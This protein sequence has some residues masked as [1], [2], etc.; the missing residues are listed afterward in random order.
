MIWSFL[1]PVTRCWSLEHPSCVSGPGE[2][3]ALSMGDALLSQPTRKG[4][5]LLFLNIWLAATMFDVTQ[6]KS[7]LD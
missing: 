7:K 5:E 4:L 6:C 3:S 2:L 1:P